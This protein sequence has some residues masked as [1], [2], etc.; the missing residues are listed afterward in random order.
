MGF[1]AVIVAAGSGS[2]AGPGAAK[3]W[4]RLAGKP[5]LRWSAE[6]LLGAGARELVVVV[7]DGAQAEAE[8]VL[9]GLSGWRTAVGGDTRSKS[10]HA[11][12]HALTGPDDEPVLVH[13]A[14]RPFVTRA[15]VEALLQAL[16]QADGVIPALPVADTL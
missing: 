13:D 5:V 16:E 6:A 12:L 14:A 7:A 10:V 15:H 4:R 9:A 2:R 1:S 3:Q 8:V 11:G